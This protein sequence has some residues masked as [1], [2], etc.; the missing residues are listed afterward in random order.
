[1]LYTD[2]ALKKLAV[3]CSQ[4]PGSNFFMQY[5]KAVADWE[6]GDKKKNRTPLRAPLD[7]MCKVLDLTK[8]T[9]AAQPDARVDAFLKDKKMPT[10]DECALFFKYT[11]GQINRPK[12]RRGNS[13]WEAVEKLEQDE[14]KMAIIK[15]VRLVLSIDWIKEAAEEAFHKAEERQEVALE[16]G[17]A[18]NTEA[19][20]QRFHALEDCEEQGEFIPT[21]DQTVFDYLK[22]ISGLELLPELPHESLA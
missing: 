11:L 22:G 14:F 13:N 21:D 4:R 6:A 16:R 1:M 12:K 9:A 19:W 3:K 8:P 17:W 7:D 15:V 2:D 10:A 18:D 5:A 20:E